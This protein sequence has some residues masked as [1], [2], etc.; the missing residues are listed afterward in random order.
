MENL[1]TTGALIVL[2]ILITPM[3]VFFVMASNINKIKEDVKAISDTIVTEGFNNLKFAN[4]EAFKGNNEKAVDYYLNFLY[5]LKQ[6]ELRA[7]KG[8]KHAE[9]VTHIENLIKGLSGKIPVEE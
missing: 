3:I 1:G 9:S 7:M 5:Y 8:M 4:R 6:S 2:A